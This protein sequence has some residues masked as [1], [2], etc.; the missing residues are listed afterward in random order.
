VVA[1]DRQNSILPPLTL[2][3]GRLD[4][5]RKSLTCNQCRK[6]NKHITFAVGSHVCLGAELARRELGLGLA[7]LFRRYPELRFT[8]QPPELRCDSLMF[9]GFKSMPLVF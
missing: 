1:E 7:A 2:Q 6:P 4:K 5:A 3:V 9:R 8:D